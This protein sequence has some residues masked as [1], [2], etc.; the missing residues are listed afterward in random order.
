MASILSHYFIQ[1]F[2][3]YLKE[4]FNESYY[5]DGYDP[6]RGTL[7]GEM[8]YEGTNGLNDQRCK[9]FIDH[10]LT[11]LSSFLGLPNRLLDYAEGQSWLNLV[12]NFFGWQKGSSKVQLVINALIMLPLNIIFTPVKFAINLVKFVTE[13]ATSTLSD[14]CLYSLT[15]PL[16]KSAYPTHDYSLTSVAYTSFSYILAGFGYSAGALLKLLHYTLTPLT[17]PIMITK[18]IWEYCN[19]EFGKVIANIC[20]GLL[21][22]LLGFSIAFYIPT[23]LSF[24]LFNDLYL[25]S[26]FAIAIPSAVTVI[27]FALADALGSLVFFAID[28]AVNIAI[29]VGLSVLG[30]DLYDYPWLNFSAVFNMTSVSLGIGL[31]CSAA[32]ILIATPL[33]D[34]I[35]S[36]RERWHFQKPEIP[37]AE[38]TNL[39]D[40][41]QENK[42]RITNEQKNR[43]ANYHGHTP[44]EVTK[45]IEDKIDLL[46]E[47]DIT[48]DTLEKTPQCVNIQYRKLAL[49]YHPDKNPG[50]ARAHAEQR[51]KKIGAAKALLENEDS[52]RAYLKEYCKTDGF[53][54]T[55]F[56]ESKRNATPPTN[57]PSNVKENKETPYRFSVRKQGGAHR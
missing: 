57:V 32:L 20:L 5:P 41:Q 1:D 47:L 15:K 9:T 55:F 46:A 51:F 38:E 18:H 52:K 16:T 2:I 24:S 27:S 48:L 30:V 12:R 26:P 21:T 42:P 22:V 34:Y 43:Y 10:S 25:A 54:P 56:A 13:V 17:S 11:K 3:Y 33:S 28:L 8:Y 45:A 31:M 49:K 36:L 40:T 14:Y 4:S 7:N 19:K 50:D 39:K 53:S 29:I 44:Y 35:D 6:S 23:I 37:E